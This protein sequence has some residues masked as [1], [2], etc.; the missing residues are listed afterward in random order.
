[1]AEEKLEYTVKAKDESASVLRRVLGDIG[2]FSHKAAE[3]ASEPFKKLGEAIRHP[4]EAL[5]SLKGFALMENI[6]IIKGLGERIGDLIERAGRLEVVRNSFEALTSSTGPAAERMARQLANAAH[7]MLSTARAMELANKAIPAGLTLSQIGTV[8]DFASKKAVSTGAAT[9]E[10]IDRIFRSLSRGAGSFLEELGVLDGGME[11]VQKE[12]DRIHGT[13]AFAQL[14]P[15]ARNARFLEAAMG[16]IQKQMGGLGVTGRESVFQ[17]ERLKGT[18]DEVKDKFLGALASNQRFKEFVRDAADIADNIANGLGGKDQ[19]K[20]LENLFGGAKSLLKAVFVDTGRLLAQG[21]VEA[22]Q[23]FGPMLLNGIKT[24]GKFLLDTLIDAA[25]KFVAKLEQQ[26]SL[27]PLFGGV[28]DQKA[29]SQVLSP[30]RPSPISPAIDS[31]FGFKGHA[32]FE[33]TSRALGAAGALARGQRLGI[34]GIENS[35]EE[36][37]GRLTPQQRQALLQQINRDRFRRARISRLLTGGQIGPE[38]TAEA[39]RAFFAGNLTQTPPRSF[40]PAARREVIRQRA[41]E[42]QREQFQKLYRDEFGAR[43]KRAGTTEDG[44]RDALVMAGGAASG[45]GE[46]F[47]PGAAGI[48]SGLFASPETAVATGRPGSSAARSTGSAPRLMSGLLNVDLGRIVTNATQMGGLLGEGVERFFGIGSGFLSGANQK[49][50]LPW[51]ASPMEYLGRGTGIMLRGLFAN[52]PMSEIG[53]ADQMRRLHPNGPSPMLSDEEFNAIMNGT[54]PQSAARPRG[55]LP[56]GSKLLDAANALLKAASALQLS[57][58]PSLAMAT[59]GR[60]MDDQVRNLR[61]EIDA[62][63]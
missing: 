24:V 41:W 40:T 9:S 54:S 38:F 4:F 30:S 10:T 62:I 13:D 63:G 15:A 19:G 47:G 25:E 31:I 36:A 20:A 35:D 18:V 21:L 17:F 3:K 49:S 26:L 61:A 27:I 39:T 46:L 48:L 11:S 23:E 57:V 42:M 32:P 34:S 37:G 28:F 6:E 44:L 7:G 58:A 52:G 50:P 22:A 12:F 14:N 59:G 1:M 43:V 8:L 16:G 51:N 45:L 2:E 56:A 53:R 60:R 55:E 29:I 5:T 33:E